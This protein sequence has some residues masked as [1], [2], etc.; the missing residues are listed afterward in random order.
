[1]TG[2]TELGCDSIE[3]LKNQINNLEAEIQDSVKFKEFYQFTFGFGKNPQQRGMELNTAIA[4]WNLIL[5]ERFKALDLWCDFLK[6]HYKRS[7]PKDTWNL[8]LDFV[9]TIKEDLSNYDEDGAWPVVIDEFVEYAKPKIA[10]RLK[11]TVV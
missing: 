11:S 7:I 2:M 6:E 8:L 1:M 9:L 5:K 10:S 4:Y 3:K